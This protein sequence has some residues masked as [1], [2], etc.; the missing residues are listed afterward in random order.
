MDY[1]SVDGN[2]PPDFAA[3][4]AWGARFAFI[5]AAYTAHGVIE[6]DT[7]WARDQAAARAAGLRVAPYMFLS[8]ATAIEAQV[9]RL[10]E[11]Y[12]EAGAGDLPV[13]LDVES[14]TAPP[15]QVLARVEA[16][17]TALR[18]RYRTVMI[19][20]SA[21]VWQTLGDPASE[22]CGGCP[23]WLK[24]S[25]PW[26][27][28]NPPRLEQVPHVDQTALPRPWREA[29]SP[30]AFIEQFQGDAIE[31]PGL[32]YKA[33]EYGTADLN[34]FL[35]YVASASDPRTAWVRG[36]LAATGFPNGTSVDA[37]ASAIRAFQ[38]ARQLTVDG[39]IGPST[40]AALCASG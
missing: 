27:R 6:T 21:D 26:K 18:A 30:G 20:T 16:A 33:N 15:A 17:V 38:A 25:Y 36:K 4:Y 5:R 35:S 28:L 31:V 39:A 3:M 7:F 14:I 19:Y 12:G 1:A 29:G 13:A 40:W 2:L 32:A 9:A 8:W 22:L 11:V 10:S 23:L 24:V 37:L 34:V